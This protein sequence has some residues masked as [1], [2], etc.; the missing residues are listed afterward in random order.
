[1]LFF[2]KKSSNMPKKNLALNEEKPCSICAFPKP[3]TKNLR[4]PVC[5]FPIVIVRIAFEAPSYH[6]S[7]EPF[8]QVCTARSSF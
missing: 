5:P 2:K 6:C 3:E 7:S 4:L 1:M 8:E